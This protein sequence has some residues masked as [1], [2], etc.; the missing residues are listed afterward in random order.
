[1]RK[2]NFKILDMYCTNCA[3]RLEGL[4][5]ELPGVRRVEASYRKGQMLVEYDEGVLSTDEIVAAVKKKGY[6]AVVK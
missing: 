3:M 5:D 1:M 4:E 6:Q 2:Q